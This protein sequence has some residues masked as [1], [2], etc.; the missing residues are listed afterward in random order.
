[1][2]PIRIRTADL[3]LAAD[4]EAVLRLV[5]LYARD[6]M[7]V[8]SPLPDEARR[9]I[10]E[11]LR[12]HP[13]CVQYLAYVDDQPVGLAVCFFVFST[14]AGRGLLNVHDLIVDPD[15]RRHGIGTALLRRVE[16]EARRNDCCKL[17]LE[18]RAD[19]PGAKSLYRRHGFSASR[20][21]YE[22]W[23]RSL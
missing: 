8:G 10:I 16:A 4:R 3:C 14:F 2:K 12:S 19:N 9:R 22:F 15:Y 1:M 5:D 13:A 6:P 17:T 11:G 20:P 7:G 23:T 18:V 21:V